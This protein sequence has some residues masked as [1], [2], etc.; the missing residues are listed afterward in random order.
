VGLVECRSMSLVG[1]A[2]CSGR[3]TIDMLQSQPEQPTIGVGHAI[4]NSEDEVG[5]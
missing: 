2:E 5:E 3:Y 4:G 1:V